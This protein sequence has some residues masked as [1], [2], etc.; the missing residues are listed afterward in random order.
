[1]KIAVEVSEKDYRNFLSQYMADILD[2]KT[3]SHRAKIAI[4]NGIPIDE[5]RI[6]KELCN[7]WSTDDWCDH[8]CAECEMLEITPKEIFE[9]IR[10]AENEDSD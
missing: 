6:V 1:M 5:Q 10:R 3:P 8:N 2:E 7:G 9:S 4:A